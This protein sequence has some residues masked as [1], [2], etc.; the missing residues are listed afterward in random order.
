MGVGTGELALSSRW[1]VD[2]PALSI[3]LVR[4]RARAWWGTTGPVTGDI[5]RTC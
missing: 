3:V 4:M 2:R 5:E 1:G